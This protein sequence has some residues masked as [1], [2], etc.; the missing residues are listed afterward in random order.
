M[1]GKVVNE[2]QNRIFLKTDQGTIKIIPSD[3][4]GRED[5]GRKGDLTYFSDRLEHLNSNVQ[6][7]SGRLNHLK[8]SLSFETYLR[9]QHSFYDDYDDR[10]TILFNEA[11]LKGN[12]DLPIIPLDSDVSLDFWWGSCCNVVVDYI[13][14]LPN[15]YKEI[16][17]EET[18]EIPIRLISNKGNLRYYEVIISRD[19]LEAHNK[20]YENFILAIV[21]GIESKYQ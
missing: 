17:D 20:E 11:K 19:M 21:E 13:V 6:I 7:L 9:I 3:I 12:R 1:Q 4:L 15:D 5:T 2:N 16:V 10:G 18:G 14:I 8:D